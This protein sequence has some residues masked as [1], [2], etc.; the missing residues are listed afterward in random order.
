MS[1]RK[2]EVLT[3]R[4]FLD[5]VES[6]L[7]EQRSKVFVMV[8]RRHEELAGKSE[9][10]RFAL[11]QADYLIASDELSDAPHVLTQQQMFEAISKW[12]RVKSL[13][14]ALMAGPENSAEA[15]IKSIKSQFTG[16]PD[17]YPITFKDN[18]E[19]DE[20]IT[21]KVIEELNHH[22]PD[23]LFVWSALKSEEEW[24]ANYRHRFNCSV[25]IGLH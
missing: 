2:P 11:S 15:Y 23:I 18:F 10:F 17:I 19:V 13:K 7:G 9:S 16:F 20:K 12:D 5:R 6:L 24:I 21:G 14:I 25:V 4:E 8:T 3:T 1:K 22:S